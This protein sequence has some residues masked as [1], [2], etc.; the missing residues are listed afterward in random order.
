[1]LAGLGIQSGI[2]VTIPS[3]RLP[4]AL[5]I[6]SAVTKRSLMASSGLRDEVVIAELHEASVEDTLRY[7]AESLDAKW[8]Q[9]PDGSK[10]LVRDSAAMRRREQG[11]AAAS[12]ETI[13]N[14]LTY[15]RK[16]L[17]EQPAEMDRRFAIT[18]LQKLA[19]EESR[20]KAA[21]EGKDY[22][23]MLVASSAVEQSPGW[24]AL[25][26]VILELG[27]KTLLTLAND[28]RAVWAEGPTA[29]QNALPP[30]A[31]KA[32]QQYRRE[33]GLVNRE[34]QITRIKVL[35]QRWE[36]GGSFNTA[37]IALDA[38][39]KEVDHPYIR[40]NDDSERMKVPFTER[41]RISAEPGEI[42][43]VV[44][45]SVLDAR[46]ALSSS[47]TDPRRAELL[48][49]WRERFLD[50]VHFEPTQWHLS[51]DL[52]AA[53]K[54][55]K[56]NLIGTVPDHTGSRFWEEIKGQT[57]SQVFARNKLAI[58]KIGDGWILARPLQTIDRDS[59]EKGSALIQKSVIAGGV[60]VDDAADW[61]GR[62]TARWPFVNW[63]GDTLE[64][65]FSGLGPYST[66]GLLMS[67]LDLRFWDAIGAIQRTNLKKG[68]RVPIG[69]LSSRAKQILH[70]IVYWHEGIENIDEPTD[71]LPSGISGGDLQ[72]RISEIPVFIAWDSGAGF[73]TN[74]VPLDAEMQGIRLAK[75]TADGAGDP[76]ADR[77][78]L[79]IYR[80]FELQ[81][82][83]EPANLAMSRELGET[84][85]DP[86]AKVLERLPSELAEQVEKARLAAIAR[87]A[88]EPGKT[89]IP[90][91]PSRS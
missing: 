53:A 80:K 26:R 27:S 48:A 5:R 83:F 77:F 68:D 89:S 9:L 28:E 33:F 56:R 62:S 88:A 76:R 71:S 58:K 25:S 35:A 38:S 32:L 82:R 51:A 52:L 23:Q 66:G 31:I 12:L 40:L 44:P 20:R 17:A 30:R 49:A 24:R 42:P 21:K 91:P 29:M 37:L 16:R 11:M 19:L 75:G 57:A 55:S 78:L 79:G 67:D 2:T 22:A 46:S 6:L 36:S 60:S 85:F 45:Q 74:P 64:L 8:E 59:R 1:M 39:G 54:A 63:L 86:K 43:I 81:F 47:S 72:L 50:P 70:Q 65:L 61:C 18:Y 10:V 4:E 73:P 41:D 34:A 84:F 90:P 7:L 13:E 3:T 69:N 14:S 87:K 15:L